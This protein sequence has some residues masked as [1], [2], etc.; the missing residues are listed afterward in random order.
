MIFAPVV[1]ARENNPGL[2][3][4]ATQSSLKQL[5]CILLVFVLYEEAEELYT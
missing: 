2:N 5:S 1:A 3:N 4:Q